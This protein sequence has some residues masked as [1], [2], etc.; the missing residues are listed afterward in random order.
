MIPPWLALLLIVAGICLLIIGC[1]SW[2]KIGKD[3]PKHV[4]IL[5]V[6]GG[7]SLGT[8]IALAGMDI[9]GWSIGPVPVWIF[10]AAILGF[11]FFVEAAKGWNDHPTRTPLLGLAAALILLL[12]VGGTVVQLATT[13]Y[14][15]NIQPHVTTILHHH[16]RG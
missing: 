6:I 4:P 12:G 11:W 5:A 15:H 14:D 13:Q 10:P 7:M 16:K 8:G 9:N 3:K 2:K 1:I